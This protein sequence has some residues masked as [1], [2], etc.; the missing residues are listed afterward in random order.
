MLFNNSYIWIESE[1]DSINEN[2]LKK[3][4]FCFL[5]FSRKK[6]LEDSETWKDSE[7]VEPEKKKKCVQVDSS[8]P[9]L[10][11]AMEESAVKDFIL[12]AK[13]SQ[14]GIID[15][16]RRFCAMVTK[17]DNYRWTDELIDTYKQVYQLLR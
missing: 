11:E 12:D 1:F 17:L 9:S 7:T 4:N 6:R 5:Y 15:F 2:K 8:L 14:Q 10:T 16:L 13:S 3:V